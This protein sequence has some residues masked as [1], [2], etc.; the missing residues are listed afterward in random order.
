MPVPLH[1]SPVLAGAVASSGAAMLS[2]LLALA[3]LGGFVFGIRAW[4]I[5][6]K[7]P[8]EAYQRTCAVKVSDLPPEEPGKLAWMLLGT[9][10]GEA[11]WEQ[12]L[13]AEARKPQF[14][15]LGAR[16]GLSGRRCDACAVLP[17]ILWEGA[18][19]AWCTACARGLANVTLP[20]DLPAQPGRSSWG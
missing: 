3:L 4:L 2:L 16:V 10:D 8:S 7:S 9:S 14:E 12:A 15:R 11:T 20:D 13:A 5:R 1:L 18:A 19:G 6:W 17:T